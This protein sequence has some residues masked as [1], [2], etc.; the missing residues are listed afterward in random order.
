MTEYYEIPNGDIIYTFD[1][2][3]INA[4]YR[5]EEP[6]WDVVVPQLSENKVHMKF[7]GQEYHYVD[8]HIG[9]DAYIYRDGYYMIWGEFLE[10]ANNRPGKSLDEWVKLRI[11]EADTA[12]TCNEAALVSFLKYFEIPKEDFETALA[13]FLSRHTP[14]ELSWDYYWVLP[15][16]D[17]IYTVD[18]EVINEYYRK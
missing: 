4:Y 13:K 1:N 7:D 6:D 3:L 14:Q 16:A 8:W 17:T 11:A 12:Q 9:P 5:Y 10:L 2:E 15:D 18:N